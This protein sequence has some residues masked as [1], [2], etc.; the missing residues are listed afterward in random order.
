TI[1]NNV[2]ANLGVGGILFSGDTN[3]GGQPLAPVPFGKI[4][5][6]TIYGGATP[7]GTGIRIE[8][9]ASPTLLNNIIASTV[10]GIS[11]DGSSTSTVVGSSLF[12][13]NTANG[14]T[15]SDAMFL[16]ANAPLFINAT[17]NNYYLAAGSLA[18]D[19]ALN[20]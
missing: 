12:R 10:T 5:N 8:Q 11:V 15:G 4:V 3:G 9:N 16:A 13:G 2:V 17:L 6:N 14:T 20:S 7:A 19:S 18:I 1:R